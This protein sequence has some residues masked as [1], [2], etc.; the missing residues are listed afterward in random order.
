MGVESM[1]VYCVGEKRGRYFAKG[2]GAPLLYVCQ[3]GFIRITQTCGNK[4]AYNLGKVLMMKYHYNMV[5]SSKRLILHDI[6]P[7]N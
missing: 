6:G 3:R 5:K 4:A 7:L 1:D 2:D